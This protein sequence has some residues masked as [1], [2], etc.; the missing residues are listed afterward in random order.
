MFINPQQFARNPAS[1]Q[2]TQQ[3]KRQYC[4]VLGCI[5]DLSDMFKWLLYFHLTNKSRYCAIFSL[6]L[7]LATRLE[8]LEFY[9]LCFLTGTT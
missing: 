5:S 1:R 3:Q 9:F 4:W 7:Y 6:S 8:F 2:S